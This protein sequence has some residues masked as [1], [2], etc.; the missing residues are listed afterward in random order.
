MTTITL[1]LDTQHCLEM[2]KKEKVQEDGLDL[3]RIPI[4]PAYKG[5]L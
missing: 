3:D 5:D 2:D 4:M 1:Y